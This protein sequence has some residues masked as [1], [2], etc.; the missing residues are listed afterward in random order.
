M[1]LGRAIWTTNTR[2]KELCS[3]LEVPV[4]CPYTNSWDRVAAI[5]GGNIRRLNLVNASYICFDL[6]Y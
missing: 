1:L 3:Q 6:F 5:D 4:N 2:G